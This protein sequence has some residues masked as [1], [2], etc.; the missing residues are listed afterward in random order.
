MKRKV[1]IALQ[2]GGIQSAFA[3]GVLDRF[4][5]DGRIDIVGISSNGLGAMLGAAFIQGTS[6]FG[7]DLESISSLLREY[8]VQINDLSKHMS[9]FVPNPLERIIEY[10]NYIGSSSLRNENF[11][12]KVSPYDINPLNINP[13]LDFIE[14]FY[15]FNSIRESNEKRLFI[16]ATHLESGKM[17]VFQNEEV[18]AKV[19]MASFCIPYVFH[20]IE[21]NGEHYWD[22]GMI[23]NPTINPLINGTDTSDIIII[24]LN[25]TRCDKIPSSLNDIDTRVREINNNAHLVRERR[26]IYFITKLIDQQK[27]REG[28]LKRLNMHVIRNNN[29]STEVETIRGNFSS[30]WND[31]TALYNHG[32]ETAR[33]WLT[34]HYADIGAENPLKNF[35][36]IF[37]DYV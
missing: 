7:D 31:I 14:G 11:A 21:I 37:E 1:A 16:G 29:P 8:W 6:S 13:F 12:Y 32:Y 35:D 20:A 28:C 2:G 24:Q 19:L 22:G 27:V 5:H 17:K 33:K 23:V 34:C 25:R 30:S 15:D 26:T 10:Y 4:L 36:K 9:S 3:W 18:D